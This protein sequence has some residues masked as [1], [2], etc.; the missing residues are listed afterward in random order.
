[1]TLKCAV[2]GLDAG[3]GKT[4]VME[5]PDMDRASAFR[6]LGKCIEELGG[7]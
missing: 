5:H 2:A 7:G 4:V 3:G 1:M 6:K